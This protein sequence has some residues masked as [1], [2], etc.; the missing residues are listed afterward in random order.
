MK[1]YLITMSVLS[2]VLVGIFYLQGSVLGYQLHSQFA[3]LVVFF[4]LQSIPI[5]WLLSMA[6]KSTSDSPMYVM[7]SVGF[8]MITGLM[9]LL[10]LFFLKV[11]NMNALAIQFAAV[12]L[13]YLIFELSVV[14]ANLRRN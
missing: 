14:L 4:F 2:A 9:L 11:D 12:Y 8:R 3:A 5:A 13:L 7:A 6:H 10:V 1:R